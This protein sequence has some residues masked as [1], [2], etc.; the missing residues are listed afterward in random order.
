MGR[1]QLEIRFLVVPSHALRPDAL[2][3]DALRPDGFGFFRIF[4]FNPQVR[5]EQGD[6]KTDRAGLGHDSQLGFAELM[7]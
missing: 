6:Q 1:L 7:V 2:R 3:P 5:L 4:L